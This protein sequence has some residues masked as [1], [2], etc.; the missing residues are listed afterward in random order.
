M[1]RAVRRQRQIVLGFLSA[2][3]VTLLLAFV[4]KLSFFLAVHAV[5]D[6]LFALYLVALLRLKQNRGTSSAS[7]RA[8]R[9]SAGLYGPSAGSPYAAASRNDD[10]YY[11]AS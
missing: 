3:V 4:P 9:A 7:S 2:A 11:R 6:V 5:V 1:P 10:Q 8:P